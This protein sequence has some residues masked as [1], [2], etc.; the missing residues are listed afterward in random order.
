MITHKKL[1][2]FL[3]DF[4]KKTLTL[5][6]L[7]SA[8]T[9]L[10]NT[11]SAQTPEKSW[12]G[13]WWSMRNAELALGWKGENQREK[14]SKQQVELF[15]N[16]LLSSTPKCR[17]VMDQFLKNNAI[18]LSPLMKFD[19][20]MKAQVE[21][22]FGND[23]PEY[24]YSKSA[25]KE[26]E[27]HFINSDPN[28]R[29]FNSKAFAGKCI[30]WALSNFDFNE[31]TKIKNINGIDFTPADIKG[32]LAGIYNGAQFFIPDDLVIGTE[33]RSQGKNS[34]AYEDVTPL[35]FVKAL[36]KTIGQGTLLEA[37]LDP[38][39]G[40]WNYPI[41]KYELNYTQV[42]SSLVEAEIEI[43]FANDEVQIDSV[44][45]NQSQRLDMKTRKYTVN[46]SVTPDW[47]G[48]IATAI[49]SKWTGKSVDN[50]P[51]A[52]I[53][54]LEDNWRET[55]LEYEDSSM[56]TEVNYELLK[57]HDGYSSVVDKLLDQ[58]YK[59]DL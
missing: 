16:C 55:I 41:H 4:M 15:S 27:I 9:G 32:I 19:L 35:Q 12:G 45:T 22:D 38:G 56:A 46:F 43:E 14:F 49:S 1:I 3:G 53:L 10:A 26:L 17:N 34:E 24:L 6:L 13:F 57:S 11:E 54:G 52:L 37:D 59:N 47:N 51:D 5:L 18:T 7:L 36:R 30:G 42:S 39:F 31:P 8:F 33:Y 40:V 23:A 28:H 21:K 25:L 20:F 29:H 48:D 2:T 44:F 50:H 58:Y